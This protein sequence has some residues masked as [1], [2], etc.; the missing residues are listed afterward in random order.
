MLEQYLSQIEEE[1][2][3]KLIQLEQKLVLVESK[4][5]SK[6]ENAHRSDREAMFDKE[7]SYLIKQLTSSL[8]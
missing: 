4:A 1:Y 6:G 5:T 7:Y 2:D 3:S 8:V